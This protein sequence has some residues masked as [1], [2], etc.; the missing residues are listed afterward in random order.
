ML[1]YAILMVN[2]AFS[3]DDEIIA[4]T[5]LFFAA[6]G[7]RSYEESRYFGVVTHECLR[8]PEKLSA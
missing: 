6:G 2:T 3:R 4:I 1:T 7:S 5:Q 8:W